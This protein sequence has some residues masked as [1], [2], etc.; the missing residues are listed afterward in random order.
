M[1]AS[2]TILPSQLGRSNVDPIIF[3]ALCPSEKD[4][5]EAVFPEFTQ[6]LTTNVRGIFVFLNITKKIPDV[7][8]FVDF[9][10]QI[11]KNNDWTPYRDWVREHYRSDSWMLIPKDYLEHHD[12]GLYPDGLMSRIK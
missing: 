10:M 11:A 4:V 8:D 3:K 1:S 6:I 2:F 5:V 12:K 9:G 7:A